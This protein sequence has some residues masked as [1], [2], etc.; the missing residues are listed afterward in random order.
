MVPEEAE[1][2]V[3]LVMVKSLLNVVSP[4]SI[5]E[6]PGPLK[7]IFPIVWPPKLTVC[8]VVEVETND[9]ADVAASPRV[10]VQPL[11]GKTKALLPVPAVPSPIE[12]VMAAS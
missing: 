12:R 6:P 2:S 4:A 3:P 9:I 5:H 1:V 8:W 7:V 10:Y 11:E